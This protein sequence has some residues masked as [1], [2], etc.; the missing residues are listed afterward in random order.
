MQ[1]KVKP[2]GQDILE[3]VRAVLNC[4]DNQQVNLPMFLDVL[5]WGILDHP[6]VLIN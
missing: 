2:P 1:V 5:S 3:K 4:M 6:E